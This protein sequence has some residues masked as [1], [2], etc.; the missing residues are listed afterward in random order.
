M[1]GRRKGH[2]RDTNVQALRDDEA[3]RILIP[4]A[5]VM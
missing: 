2:D 5:G 1:D 4:F 3:K